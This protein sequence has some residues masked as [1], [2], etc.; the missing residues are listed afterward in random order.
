MPIPIPENK[1]IVI[2]KNSRLGNYC[3]PAMEISTDHYDIS[4]IISGDRKAITPTK[5]YSYHKGDIAMGI[6]YL[7]HRTLSESDEPYENYLIKF[8]PDFIKP[9][10]DTVG[11]NIFDELNE[12]RICHFEEK[13]QKLIKNMFEEMLFEYKK[14]KPYTELILQGMLF[15]LLITVYENKL[16][17]KATHFKSPLT[18]PILNAIYYIENNYAND[19]TLEEVAKIALFSSGHF[20]RL[21]KKQLGISFS[22]YLINVRLNH[23]KILLIKTDKSI[24]EIALETGFCNGDYLSYKFKEKNKMTPTNF[25]QQKKAF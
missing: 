24:S 16:A 15:R 2:Q 14:N 9:F 12:E 13:N 25:R 21:F 1:Q 23:V 7:Y 17:N 5:S 4:Y 18:E 10:T 22:E 6:P 8:T 20:S 11:K 3:M 19:I